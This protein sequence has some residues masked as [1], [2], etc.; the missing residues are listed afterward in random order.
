MA[1]MSKHFF[2]RPITI[3]LA[4]REET[5]RKACLRILQS[6]KWMKV[7]AE[8]TSGLDAFA[9]VT[10]LKPSVLLLD[11]NLSHERGASLIP[12]LHRKS[13]DSKVIMLV[14][15]AVEIPILEA[16]SFGAR[17]YLEEKEI[18][19]F[20]TKAIQAVDAGE[21]WVPRTMVAKIIAQL[22]RLPGAKNY[23]RT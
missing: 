7:V 9:A 14:S 10:Q 2:M 3:V 4:V 22:A 21:A 16:L 12:A 19:D 15:R 23:G 20:L 6:E 17:G 1:H 5:P 8:A 13:P 18:P 11:M